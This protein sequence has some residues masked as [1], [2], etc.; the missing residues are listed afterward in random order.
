MPNVSIPGETSFSQALSVDGHGIYLTSTTLSFYYTSCSLYKLFIYI[1]I[2][3]NSLYFF[4]P[5]SE[6]TLEVKVLGEFKNNILNSCYV[7]TL[8]TIFTFS[9][10]DFESGSGGYPS[11]NHHVE[12]YDLEK[13][14]FS[15]IWKQ[16]ANEGFVTDFGIRH[17]MGC[18]SFLHYD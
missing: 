15:V 11:A 3:S 5:T 4:D 2:Y 13:K 12:I 8:K 1:G 16:Q 17:S 7:D 10:A 18:F 14:L 9:T 6:S